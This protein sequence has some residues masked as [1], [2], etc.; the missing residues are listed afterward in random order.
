MIRK[1]FRNVGILAITEGMLQLKGLVLMPFLTRQ[2]GPINYGVWSQVSVLISTITP[3]VILGTDSAALRLLPGIDALKQKRYFSAWVVFLSVLAAL[4]ALPLLFFKN[5]LAQLFFGDT[6]GY[7]LFLPLAAA[8][9][10]TSTMVN[11]IR[12]WFRIQNNAKLFGLSNIL[13]ALFNIFAVVAMLLQNQG[14]YLLVLY[15][16]ISD[17]LLFGI[18][19]IVVFLKY[20]WAKPDF[21]ILAPML[22]FGLPLVPA[23][24]AIWGLN[25][26]DRLFLVRY[27]TLGEIG[28]YAVA[29][30][31]AYRIIPIFILPLS[32]M[33]FNSAAELYNLGKLDVL[34]R[35]FERSAG[36]VLALALPAS[37]GLFLLGDRLLR[38]FAT[39][40]FARGAPVIL[41]ISTGY[42]FLQVDAYF[43][44]ALGLIHKQ[45]ISTW[46]HLLGVAV[47]FV[48]CLLL[49][50]SFSILGAAIATNVSFLSLM[51]TTLLFV[52]HYK[53]WRINLKFPLKILIATTLMGLGIYFAD[54]FWIAQIGNIVGEILLLTGTGALIYILCLWTMKIL[55]RSELKLAFSLLRP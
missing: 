39:G 55:N 12:N 17:V 24:F 13:Q 1:Y 30:N 49:I 41:F 3:L 33:F 37:A 50:P 35:L 54:A 22:K 18:F 27:S 10:I 14:V 40:E 53:I 47:N 46:A 51:L 34:Q 11:A 2:F 52:N 7:V 29:Y 6:D 45:Y 48:L 4:F 44:A 21:S 31:V 15:T 25:Y 28:V 5:Q 19:S 26:L 16:L 9:L 38:I 8:W 43:A 20:G 36:L 32:T 23:G 42:V